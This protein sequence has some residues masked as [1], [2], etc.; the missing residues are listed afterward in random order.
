MLKATNHRMARVIATLGASIGAVLLAGTALAH[1][2]FLAPHQMVWG[3]GDMIT[4]S[5]TSALAY[6]DI[7]FAI[8]RDRIKDA[9]AYVASDEVESL[10]YAQTET[11]LEISFDTETEGFGVLAVTTLPR[12]GEIPAEDVELYFDELDA[13]QAVRDRF[14]ALPGE[15]ALMRSYSKLSKTVFCVAEC[16]GGGAVFSPLGHALEF[17]PVQGESRSFALF[18]DGQALA[19]HRVFIDTVDGRTHRTRTNDMGRFEV[20]EAATGTVLM[21]A[22]WIDVPTSADGNYHSDQASL[23]INLD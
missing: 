7:Q 6:P 23:T 21:S 12:S 17:V 22:V 9:V 8:G 19:G 3:A 18:R 1:K 2:T 14:D 13:S 20:T 16:S 5:F 10:T 11:S 4:V 15:P